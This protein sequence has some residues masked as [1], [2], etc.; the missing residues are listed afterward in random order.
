[1]QTDPGKELKIDP[2]VL[3]STYFGG[4]GSENAMACVVDKNKDVYLA[5]YTNSTVGLASGGYQNTPGG[6]IDG[7]IVKFDS[8]GS[9]LWTTYYGGTGTDIIRSC[10]VDKNN[11]VYFSGQTNSSS[12]IASGGYQNTIAGNDDGF[13]VKLNSSGTRLWATYFGGGGNEYSYTCCT[14]KNNNVYFSGETTSATGISSNGGHQ[15]TYAGSGDNFLVKFN[16]NGAKL[17]ATYYGG[18]GNE[19]YGSCTVDNNGNVFLAGATK[20]VNNIS[21]NGHQNTRAGDWD[22]YLVKFD[23][24]GVRLW[25]TYYGS[26]GIDEGQACTTDSLGNVYLAGITDS[27]TGIAFNGYQNSFAGWFDAFLVKFNAA[28]VRQW[29]TY[30]GGS[31]DEYG[32]AC[33]VDNNGNV[34][35][36]GET[37]SD[38]GIASDGIQNFYGGSYNDAFIVKFNSAGIRQWGTY[39]G[40]TDQDIGYGCTS[41][42]TFLYIAGYTRSGTGIASNGFQG[43]ISGTSDATL[44]KI[45]TGPTINACPNNSVILTS[46]ITGA[47]YQWEMGT[48]A[49]T[50]VNVSN[51]GAVTQTLQLPNL[52]SSYYGYYYRCRVNATT[53][54]DV[55]QIRFLNTWTGSVNSV[56]ENPGNWS[57]GIL[58]DG[59]TDVIINGGPVTLNSN[60][61]CRTLKVQPGVS[62]TIATGNTLIITH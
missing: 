10:A 33:C 24:S 57:C 56:W 49:V 40:G 27:T 5:G 53:Y 31:K 6:N 34:Y 48:D 28:G 55:Y 21:F 7:Y 52:P 60:G 3:W 8:A 17:W 41:D 22:S 19:E 25:A 62:F 61:I 46:N 16:T 54:S 13:V 45:N 42:G 37:S 39:Y 9:R 30:Y 58:P 1:M 51:P 59:N 35:L 4:T 38:N 43:T 47:S 20:S 12:G 18:S 23:S 14:D 15:D 44:I 50:W 29:G 32:N 11:D 36:T 2:Y 26:P